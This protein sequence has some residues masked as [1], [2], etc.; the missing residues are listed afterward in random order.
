MIFQSDSLTTLPV[1]FQLIVN[2]VALTLNTVTA[3]AYGVVTLTVVQVILARFLILGPP[4][5]LS[6]G[7]RFSVEYIV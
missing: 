4:L 5:V 6:F 3:I 2:I 7:S 1:Y